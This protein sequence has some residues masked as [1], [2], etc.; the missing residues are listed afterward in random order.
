MY[1]AT[2]LVTGAS[3][4]IGQHL[5]EYFLKHRYLVI[6]LTRQKNKISSKT[7]LIWV[8][9]FEEIQTH[10]IDYVVNL[11][12]ENISKGRWSTQ[13]KQALIY[14]RVNLTLALYQWLQQHHIQPK[15]IISGSAIGY[16]GI[17]LTEKWCNVFDE[18]G[19][20]Q[21][22]FVSKLCQEWEN[23][24]LSFVEQNTK[25]IRL[26]LVLAKNGGVLSQMLKPIRFNLFK[27]IGIGHQPIVWVHIDDVIRCIEFLFSNCSSQKIYNLVAPEIIMQKQFADVAAKILKKNPLF[28][29]PRSLVRCLLGEQS[30]LILNGQFVIPKAL[31]QEGFDFRYYVLENALTDLLTT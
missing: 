13:R 18:T 9:H 17:D 20:T 21:D 23:T 24:A 7:N 11:A 22:I 29:C 28:Q 1:K 25:I 10:Q 6:G 19:P 14:S 30:Q 27:K 26:G 12:G 16:Y 2:V 3:G 15:C 31:I 4:F 8:N 5:L